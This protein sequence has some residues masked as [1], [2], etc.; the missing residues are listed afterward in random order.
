M[1][2]CYSIPAVAF[3]QALA[4]ADF[5]AQVLTAVSAM[6]GLSTLAKIS[7]VIVLIVASMKVTVLNQMIWSKLPATLQ[8]LTAPILGLIAGII[9]QGSSLTLSSALAYVSAGAGALAMHE[10]LDAVKGLPGLGPIYVTAITFVEGFLNPSVAAIRPA[11]NAEIAKAETA[12][13]AAI[14]AVK[15]A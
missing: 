10:L 11:L 2:Y 1:P 3:A 6:G 13:K 4:P 12:R 9:S 8:T 15:K 14:I 7:A 5:A